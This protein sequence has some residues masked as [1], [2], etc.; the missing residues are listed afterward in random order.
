MIYADNTLKSAAFNSER[1]DCSDACPIDGD[2]MIYSSTIKGSYSL[3]YADGDASVEIPEVN[4]D[5]NELGADFFSYAEYENL[6]RNTVLGDVNAD[7]ELNIADVV[8]LQK[9][10][11][12]VPDVSLANWEAADLCQN[13]ELNVLDLCLMKRELLRPV[14][15]SLPKSPEKS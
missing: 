14:Q 11:L 6:I 12:A 9:W 5:R 13:G 2:K 10:L 8:L 7:G 3:Y 1:Y 15:Y 4:T